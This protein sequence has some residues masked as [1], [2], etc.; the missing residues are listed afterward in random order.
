MLQVERNWRLDHQFVVNVHQYALA[1]DAS[2][3]TH[4]ITT[5]V[6]SPAQISSLFDVITY[7]KGQ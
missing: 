4:P 5:S 7:D 6:Y 1:A 2:S 3:R